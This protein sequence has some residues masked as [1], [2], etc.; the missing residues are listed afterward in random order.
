MEEFGG[1]LFIQNCLSKAHVIGLSLQHLFNE[2]FK[3]K[4]KYNILQNI[5]Y[6]FY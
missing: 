5:K 6:V 4:L 1:K 3:K 2:I